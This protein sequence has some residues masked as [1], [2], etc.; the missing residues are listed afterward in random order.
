MPESTASS[1]TWWIYAG[2]AAIIITP[3]ALLYLAT[4]GIV[5]GEEFCPDDFSRRSFFYNKAPWIGTTLWGLTHGNKKSVLQSRLIGD[6]LIQPTG[7]KR[8]HLVWDNTTDPNQ[9]RAYDARILV[10]YL[11][12][13]D[14]A[15]ESYWD[16]WID[17]HPQSATI[18][19]PAVADLARHDLYWGIPAVM[20]LAIGL[21]TDG[22]PDFARQLDQLVSDA[23]AAQAQ[24]LQQQ[25]K[26]ELAVEWFDRALN[27][28]DSPEIR[29]ARRR[30]A[31]LLPSPTDSPSNGK[32]G[33]STAT[34]P[35]TNADAQD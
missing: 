2:I 14:D 23:F 19:W 18:F 4:A 6:G 25:G 9:S 16:R 20:R 8:W 31:D 17:E 1:K 35:P 11:D 34:A 30:S 26:H 5:A 32:A 13:T 33:D 3:I 29:A 7:N 28:L 21:K 24:R 12:M 22:D 10:T 27:Y 15:F